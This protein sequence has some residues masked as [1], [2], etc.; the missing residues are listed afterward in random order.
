M[1]ELIYHMYHMLSDYSFNTDTVRTQHTVA[2]HIAYG[3][4]NS[5]HHN[6][7]HYMVRKF[8]L[9]FCC[10]LYLLKKMKSVNLT[11]PA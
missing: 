4:V 5:F 2:C 8:L 3:P 11:Q 6:V 10:L 7:Q 1:P 9:C